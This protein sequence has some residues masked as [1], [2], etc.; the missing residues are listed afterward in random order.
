MKNLSSKVFVSTD[1]ES[2]IVPE[3]ILQA[4]VSRVNKTEASLA[5]QW[6]KLLASN[7]GGADLIPGWETKIPHAYGAKNVNKTN[8]IPDPMELTF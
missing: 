6:L 8:K 4:K 5:V 3:N 1:T 2:Y 7:A